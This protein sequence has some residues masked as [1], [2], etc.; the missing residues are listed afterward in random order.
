MHHRLFNHGLKIEFFDKEVLMLHQWHESYLSKAHRDFSTEFVLT[1]IEHLNHEHKDRNKALKITK[2]NIDRWGETTSKSDLAVLENPN[3]MLKLSNITKEIDYL[4]YSLLPSS[5][6]D[7]LELEIINQN[8]P[9]V[10]NKIKKLL[11]KKVKQFYS[12]EKVNDLL[13]IQ[14]IAHYRNKNYIYKVS[15]DAQ[16]ITLKIKL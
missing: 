8:R 15:K 11:G 12:M 2:V 7:V 16:K 10:K 6:G 4:L 14:L 13:L 3:L 9:S 5:Q 1:G